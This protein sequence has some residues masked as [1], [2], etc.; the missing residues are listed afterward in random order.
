MTLLVLGLVLF[1]GISRTT[2]RTWGA[3]AAGTTATLPDGGEL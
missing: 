1:L 3:S 2:S